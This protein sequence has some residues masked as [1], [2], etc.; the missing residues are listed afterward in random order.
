MSDSPVK[1][2]ERIEIVPLTKPPAATVRVPGSKSIT[3][4]ALVLAALCC[5]VQR[6]RLYGYLVSEDT[7]VMIA[8]LRQLGLQVEMGRT[9]SEPNPAPYIAVS[10]PDLSRRLA[11]RAALFVANSGTS[12]RFLTAM[13]SLSPGRYRL[14][15]V[16]RM[17][18]RP[19]QDL[20]DALRQLGVD[21]RSE[22]GNS[23]PPVI[24]EGTGW[25][26]GHVRIRGDVSSQF[27]SG[28]LMAA[29]FAP[30]DTLIEVEGPLVSEP[31]V[32]MTLRMLRDW[33][34]KIERPRPDRFHIP[35]GQLPEQ[36]GYGA[37]DIEP[38]ASAASY[39]WAAAAITGGEVRVEGFGANSLQGDVRFVDV[40][41]RMGCRVTRAEVV[42]GEPGITVHGGQLRGIDVDMNDIS[43]TVMT[44]GAV[45][46]F[47]DGPTTIR[48]VAHIRHKETDRLAA[49]AA[50]LRRV[51]ADVDELADGLRI[52]PRPLHGAEIETY[53]DHRMAMSLALVG[54]KVPGVVIKDPGC[55]AKTYPNFFSDLEKLRDAPS[56][57]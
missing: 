26:N 15:G 29:P 8:A 19:I 7:E 28:L 51:G 2:P 32:A 39:F 14:D 41:E 46:L 12:M 35:G 27:L 22:A 25:K 43:D 4:R 44:L 38:D 52:T 31:Y 21:A 11:P 36:Y 6:P 18:E 49:L 50:E 34:V 54:L 53:N 24:V 10:R 33:L 48:N 57:C 16:P 3:N 5:P 9:G 1:Y 30:Q 23:C 45:A 20:L 17:R 55:V 47:A 56:S 13:V 40:L 42:N 37:Y